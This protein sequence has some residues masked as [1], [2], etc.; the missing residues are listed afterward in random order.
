MDQCFFCFDCCFCWHAAAFRGGLKP[1]RCRSR[2]SAHL[3]SAD[4]G[5]TPGVNSCQRFANCGQI[6]RCCITPR[7]SPISPARQQISPVWGGYRQPARRSDRDRSFSILMQV[8]CKNS[9][10]NR[11]QLWWPFQASESPANRRSQPNHAPMPAPVRALTGRIVAVAL[12]SRTCE[13]YESTS[14]SR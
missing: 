1:L 3:H 2:P 13:I 8:I 10:A 6:H 7:N 12:T 9:Y 11:L 14:T 4:F 5:S